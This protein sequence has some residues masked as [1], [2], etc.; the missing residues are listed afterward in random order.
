MS[1]FVR[2]E[3]IQYLASETS[4]TENKIQYVFDEILN[5]MTVGDYLYIIEIPIESLNHAGAA[6]QFL[7]MFKEKGLD[8]VLLAPKDYLKISKIVKKQLT[9]ASV[10]A[11]LQV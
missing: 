1:N 6:K 5:D 7:Q 4:F 10:Y 8:N 2:K 3:I 9:I 11:I